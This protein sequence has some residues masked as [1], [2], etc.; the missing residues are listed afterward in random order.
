MGNRIA[1][2]KYNAAGAFLGADFY[3]RDAQGNNLALYEYK[4]IGS[5][6]VSF[7]CNERNVYGSSRLGVYK[8][9]NS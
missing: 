2:K 4:D 5:N 7:T 3:V 6:M 9:K 1:K 8:N